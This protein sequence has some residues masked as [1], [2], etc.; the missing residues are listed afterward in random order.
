MFAAGHVAY[1]YLLGKGSGKLLKTEI[2]IPLILALSIAPD[3][4]L[5]FRSIRHRGATHSLI[6]LTL[7]L[8]P[9]LIKYGKTTIP[10][11]IAVAQHSLFG[12]YLTGGVALLWPMTQTYYGIR[13]SIYGPQN[14]ILE[15]GAFL[16]AIIVMFVTRDILTLLK[17][18]RTNLLLIIPAVASFVPLF[19]N[20]PQPLPAS[21]V[22][23]EAVFLTIYASSILAQI[24]HRTRFIT[25]I[26][27]RLNRRPTQRDS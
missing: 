11:M 7:A 16:A 22:I 13:W 2:N 18:S 6:I 10:Y 8:I 21:L 20:E 23:P 4:D 3:V 14:L 12:D 25:F 1:G 24:T 5:V 19:L 27:S 9:F 15:W 17:P 26:E